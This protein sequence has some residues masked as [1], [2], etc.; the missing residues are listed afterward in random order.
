MEDVFGDTNLL[1]RSV[2]IGHPM[3]Q[4]ARTAIREV[5]ERG[6][7]LVIARQSLVE[8]WAVATRPEE[9][10]GLELS[11]TDARRLVDTMRQRFPILPE[12]DSV[13]DLWL[14]LVTRYEV[15]GKPTHDARLV[16]SML[17]NGVSRVLTF[18]ARDF[19]RFA[20]ITVETP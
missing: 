2:H 19:S 1:L 3:R 13:L 12:P 10:N 11:S 5:E 9:A 4:V 8:L 18:N 16:A 20:E 6:D 7:R 14:D 17:A 15:R